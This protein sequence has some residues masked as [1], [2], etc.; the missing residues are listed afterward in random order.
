[1]ALVQLHVVPIPVQSLC[2]DVLGAAVRVLVFFIAAHV[3]FVV[4]F[5]GQGKDARQAG[6]VKCQ[7]LVRHVIRR[8]DHSGRVVS[9]PSEHK[10]PHDDRLR[11]P[12]RRF[13]LRQGGKFLDTGHITTDRSACDLS[14]KIQL[15]MINTYLVIL[16]VLAGILQT[17]ESGHHG[18]HHCDS[19]TYMCSGHMLKTAFR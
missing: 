1:M 8:E 2:E 4:H 3:A 19:I 15:A 7:Q 10:G 5:L 17:L 14:V 9:E 6:C 18:E 16:Q 12:Q 11:T 13:W